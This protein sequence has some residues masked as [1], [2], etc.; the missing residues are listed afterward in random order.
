MPWC[1]TL[2]KGHEDHEHEEE[3]HEHYLEL[4]ENTHP[5][6]TAQQKL[7]LICAA[8]RPAAAASEKLWLVCAAVRPAAAA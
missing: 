3:D 7:W 4:A 8:V 6:A 1:G 2:W 5:A